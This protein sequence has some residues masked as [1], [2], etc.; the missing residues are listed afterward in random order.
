MRVEL[1]ALAGAAAKNGLAILAI[2]TSGD[3]VAW[4]PQAA[5][6]SRPPGVI[7]HYAT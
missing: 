1:I 5:R 6:I 3:A 2:G 7:A 4:V